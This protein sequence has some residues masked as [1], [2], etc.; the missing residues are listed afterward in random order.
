MAL[1]DHSGQLGDEAGVRGDVHARGVWDIEHILDQD[2]LLLTDTLASTRDGQ[3]LVQE[4]G[5][6]NESLLA[7]AIISNQVGDCPQCYL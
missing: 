1:G 6:L 2:Q 5:V 3:H 4:L 7:L